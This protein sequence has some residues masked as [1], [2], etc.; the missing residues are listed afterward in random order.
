MVLVS[1]VTSNMAETNNTR[2]DHFMTHDL[3][4]KEL[5]LTLINL[6]FF[7]PYLGIKV[8]KRGRENHKTVTVKNSVRFWQA[9]LKT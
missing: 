5:D 8:V 1:P 7:F 9:K 4:L 2:D 6:F 3:P